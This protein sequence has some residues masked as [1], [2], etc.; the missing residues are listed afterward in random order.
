M[1]ATARGE[2]LLIGRRP[3]R[4]WTQLYWQSSVAP[5]GS[6]NRVE[7]RYGSI[8]GLEYEVPQSRLYCL[9]I[10]VALCS[11]AFQCIC[12]VI[13]RSSMTMKAHTY[14]IIFGRP[15]IGGK[16]SPPSPWRRHCRSI[17]HSVAEGPRDAAHQ[18][19]SRIRQPNRLYCCQGGYIFYAG[20][21]I[22]GVSC[23]RRWPP[24]PILALTTPVAQCELSGRSIGLLMEVIGRK[25]SHRAGNPATVRVVRWPA[26]GDTA[27]SILRRL[28]SLQHR[29]YNFLLDCCPRK[30]TAKRMGNRSSSKNL[31]Q[32]GCSIS[33]TVI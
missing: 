13:R 23:R 16:L 24:P 14:Y 12:R 22:A 26:A 33:K 8:G 20:G 1:V 29:I 19:L 2:K 28:S 7:V 30:L 32:L 5:P 21:S 9:C 31:T 15:P 4:N 11:T 10:N 6:C 25:F 18:K 3:L 17:V 27:G